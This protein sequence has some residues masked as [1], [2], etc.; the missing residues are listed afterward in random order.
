[1]TSTRIM[2]PVE[3]KERVSAVIAVP[4]RYGERKKTGIIISHGAGNDMNNSMIVFLAKGLAE[5][6]YLTLRFNFPYREKGR[7]KPDSQHELVSAWQSVYRYLKENSE[8]KPDKIVATG[9][10]MG[11]R[12]A[13][14]MSAD[15]LLTPERLVFFGYPLHAP[16]KKDQPRDTH[17]YQITIPMLFF[18][19][20]R[21]PFCDMTTLKDVL[22]R[23]DTSW[24]LETID[25]GDHSFNLPKSAETSESEVYERI[26]NKTVEWLGH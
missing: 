20:T 24:D 21:D 11:G 10:S 7:K 1:M 12:V 26:L 14:Q 3:E 13:A 2:I 5:A 16:G 23:L 18:A 17:L 22:C 15:G 8:F 25:G 19:G 6:G 9:K 4:E